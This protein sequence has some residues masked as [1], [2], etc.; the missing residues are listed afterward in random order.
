MAGLI[1]ILGFGFYYAN[2]MHWFHGNTKN[3]PPNILNKKAGVNELLRVDTNDDSI[4]FWRP[5]A[6]SSVPEKMLANQILWGK[7]LIVNTAAYFGPKGSILRMSNGM[8]CQN[9]HLEAGT[10]IWGNNYGSVWA[11]YPKYRARSGAVEDLT[12]R[13]ND[14]FLRSLN[15]KALD[16]SGK[17][18]RAI[19]AYIEFVGSNVA[20]GKNAKGSGLYELPFLNR[21]LN[22]N[23]GK[24]LFVEKCQSCH[25]PNGGGLL[26]ENKLSYLYPPLWGKQSYNQGAGLYRMGRLAGFIKYNMPNGTNFKNPILSDDEAWDLAGYINSQPRP[27]FDTK[28]DWPNIFEKPY[29]LPFGPYADDFSVAQHKFGP[30]KP[31]TE[32]AKKLKEK[33]VN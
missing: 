17:D 9:C 26:A 27:G 6:L 18:M 14:C 16:T 19:K 21:P 28:S 29:D 13:I 30:Y 10:K 32:A 2:S 24:L 20:E 1:I 31:I 15:G 12:K 5:P 3:S 11:N 22:P 7:E 4:S 33:Q 25:Q 8:N 23:Q